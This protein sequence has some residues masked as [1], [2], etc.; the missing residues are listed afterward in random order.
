MNL[1][2]DIFINYGPMLLLGF[3]LTLKIVTCSIILG[4]PLGLFL[5]LGRRSKFFIISFLST[6]FIEVFRNTPKRENPRF[7]VF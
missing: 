4:V 1:E 2:F 5:A 7:E 6:S 3:W